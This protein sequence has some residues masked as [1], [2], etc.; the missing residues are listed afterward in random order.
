MN[1]TKEN[2]TD[3]KKA[4]DKLMYDNMGL[5]N[6][7]TTITDEEWLK[8]YHGVSATDAV[9]DEITSIQEHY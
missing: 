7:S 4:L 9:A 2:I 3:W 5:R 6:Y 1:L 8:K